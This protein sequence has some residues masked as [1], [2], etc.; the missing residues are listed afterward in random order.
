M[1][2]VKARFNIGDKLMFDLSLPIP[3]KKNNQAIFKKGRKRF[4][5]ASNEY[6]IWEKS[7]IFEMRARKL[8]PSQ[9]YE[10]VAKI[11]YRFFPENKR[12]FDHTNKIESINDMLVKAGVLEDDEWKVIRKFTSETIEIDKE[13]PRVEV[14]IK[15]IG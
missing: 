4:I 9:P 14:L 15:V 13:N 2:K 8:I 10:K 6:Q 7:T 12:R 11:V 3:S 1:D 5:S